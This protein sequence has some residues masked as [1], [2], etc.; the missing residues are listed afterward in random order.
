MKDERILGK[1]ADLLRKNG[2]E[3]KKRD[4][5][6]EDYPDIKQW[7]EDTGL[8]GRAFNAIY[9]HYVRSKFAGQREEKDMLELIADVKSGKVCEIHNI[10]EK[11]RKEIAQALRITLHVDIE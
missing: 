4:Y 9:G 10:G 6:D 1:L 8:S 11:T 2:Y 7:L 5:A 3:V